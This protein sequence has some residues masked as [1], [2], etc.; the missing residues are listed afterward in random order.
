MQRLSGKV[1][2]VTGAGRHRGLGLAIAERLGREGAKVVVT[3]I[4]VPATDL[5]SDRIGTIAEMNTVVE[6][7]RA[8]GVDAVACALDV[9]DEVQ[10]QRAIETAVERFG[11]LD[12]LVNNAGVGFLMEPLVEM[13]RER[14]QTVLDVNLLGAFLCTKHAARRMIAQGTGGRVINIASVAAKSGS[15][16]GGSPC[17]TARAGK[18]PGDS[19]RS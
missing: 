11:A 16:T 19:S 9:R 10:V 5:G 7:L 18:R 1:A 12:I 17:R 4:G 3:D 15:R 14:W 2:L 13:S 6:A 8:A